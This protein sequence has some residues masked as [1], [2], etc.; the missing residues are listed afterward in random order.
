MAISGVLELANGTVPATPGA[1]LID[2][3]CDSSDKR[4]KTIDETPTTRVLVDRD[5]VETLTN[6][7]MGAC[8]LTVPNFTMVTGGTLMTTPTAGVQEADAAAFYGTLDTTNG[9]RF[10]DN[11]NY[12]RLTGSGS[13]IT[14]IADFFGSNSAIPTVLNGVYEIEWHCYWVHTVAATG[15]ITWTIVNTQTVTQMVAEYMQCPIAGI[16]TAGAPQT[17]AV[18]A[19]TSASVALPASA[20]NTAI[21]SHYAKI[22]ATI[23]AAT[24]GNV[25]LRMTASAGTATPSRDSFFRVRRLP[26]GN[27]GTFAA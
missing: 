21:A 24:A 7:S 22:R 3:Y 17:A 14:T 16:G 4:I 1:G 25:R 15:T 11:W 12:F 26:A 6:K 8:S 19:Q 9:R 23:E 13:G 27:A 10:N 20:A 18:I 2:I 5:S